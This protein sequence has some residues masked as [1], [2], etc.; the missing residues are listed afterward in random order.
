VSLVP[1]DETAHVIVSDTGPGIPADL[2]T[3]VFEPFF[4]IG[5]ARSARGFGLGLSIA[6]DNV[7]RHQGTIA[8]EDNHPHGLSVRISLPAGCSDR[9]ARGNAGRVAVSPAPTQA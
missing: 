4:K 7:E 5:D 1:D 6:R 8:L 9:L 3:R 2:R